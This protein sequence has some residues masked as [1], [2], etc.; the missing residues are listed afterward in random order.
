MAPSLKLLLIYRTHLRNGDTSP[1]V[2]SRIKEKRPDF[3][4]FLISTKWLCDIDF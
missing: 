1:K 2:G 3:Q 4:V